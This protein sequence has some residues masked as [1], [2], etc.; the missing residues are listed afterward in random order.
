MTHDGQHIALFS[1]CAA[2]NMDWKD[3]TQGEQEMSSHWPACVLI[4]SSPPH[5]FFSHKKQLKQV[6]LF[7][8]VFCFPWSETIA[9]SVCFIRSQERDNDAITVQHFCVVPCYRMTV[10]PVVFVQ[11]LG[12]WRWKRKC[13]ILS[14]CKK[15]LP[16]LFMPTMHNAHLQ[17]SLSPFLFLTFFSK[18]LEIASSRRGR[19]YFGFPACLPGTPPVPRFST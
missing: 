11:L 6:H 10:S 13:S 8:K 5:L 14:E 18:R 4:K 15:F 7:S 2:N 12:C 1:S 9:W 17:I 16:A 19:I 3:H